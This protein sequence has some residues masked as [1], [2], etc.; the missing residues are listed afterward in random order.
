[1]IPLKSFQALF[2]IKNVEVGYCLN[3]WQLENRLGLTHAQTFDHSGGPDG[4]LGT[5][6]GATL[7]T[8]HT[9]LCKYWYW[10]VNI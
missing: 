5:K 8:L 9:F 4:S 3:A 2:K 7:V 10:Y 6:M 1:M